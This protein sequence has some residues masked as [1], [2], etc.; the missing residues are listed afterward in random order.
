MCL[1]VFPG[2][3]GKISLDS[4]LRVMWAQLATQTH[5]HTHLERE[6]E[7]LDASLRVTDLSGVCG[8]LVSSLSAICENFMP[9]CITMPTTF[10]SL[11]LSIFNRWDCQCRQYLDVSAESLYQT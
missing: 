11:A 7:N 1:S 4:A 10:I 8:E 9:Q 5:T 6:Q 3:V 2:T